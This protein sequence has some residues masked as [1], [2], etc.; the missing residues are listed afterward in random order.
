[1]QSNDIDRSCKK[2][3]MN[4]LKINRILS[5]ITEGQFSETPKKITEHAKHFF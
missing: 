3:T 1:M 5:P 4:A 2:T